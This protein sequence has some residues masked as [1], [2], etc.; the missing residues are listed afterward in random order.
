MNGNN[1]FALVPKSPS[2]IEK[3]EPAAKRI[4][5]AMV[6]DI[7]TLAPKENAAAPSSEIQVGRNKLEELRITHRAVPQFICEVVNYTVYLRLLARSE[8]DQSMWLWNGHEWQLEKPGARSIDKPEVLDDARLESAIQW[9]RQLDWFTPKPGLWCA[10]E[11]ENI[12]DHLAKAWR[13]RPA[14]AEYLS[15][16]AFDRFLSPRR[17]QP[18]LIVK[19][20][21]INW[22]AVSAEW[23]HEAIKLTAADLQRLQTASDRFVKLFFHRRLTPRRNL[24]LQGACR[25]FVKLP[26]AG[27]VELDTSAVNNVRET[28]AG[29]GLEKLSAT[30]QRVGLERLARLE[31]VALNHF[32]DNLELRA[33]RERLI[34]LVAIARVTSRASIEAKP[35]P[36]QKQGSVDE[37]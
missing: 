2:A 16:A 37:S 23:T 18:R 30:P 9:L 4:M 31:E 20:T 5:S 13:G 34:D 3:S 1:D 7:L 11:N 12:L 28:M 24:R 36:H 27:W 29:L 19:G 8:R 10:D 14:E 6:T 35:P 17:L 26:D 33:L 21:G 32:V 15:N 22:V 25:R